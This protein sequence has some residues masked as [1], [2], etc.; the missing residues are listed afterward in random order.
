MRTSP[1]Y[2]LGGSLPLK[3]IHHQNNMVIVLL[4]ASILTGFIPVLIAW[5][6][7]AGMRPYAYAL[8]AFT[9]AII[10]VLIMIE[11]AE[12][13]TDSVAAYFE[14]QLN[15]IRKENE[16]KNWDIKNWCVDHLENLD[17]QFHQHSELIKAIRPTQ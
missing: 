12:N 3:V 2:P 8:S 11:R 15:A 9:V 16:D 13:Y 17:R 1:A 6:D 4:I 7:P 10:A 14:S 5:K